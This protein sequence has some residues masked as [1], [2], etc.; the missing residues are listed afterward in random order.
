[1]RAIVSVM[2]EIGVGGFNLEIVI[3]NE[4]SLQSVVNVALLKSNCRSFHPTQ[5]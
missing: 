5:D 4:S 2:Q 1:M 3:D